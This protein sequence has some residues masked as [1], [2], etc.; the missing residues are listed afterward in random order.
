MTLIRDRLPLTSSTF[1]RYVLRRSEQYRD[2]FATKPLKSVS[3][4]IGY[5]CLDVDQAKIEEAA[6]IAL[7]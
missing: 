6:K 4:N 5:A 3:D 7:A 1:G 2:R